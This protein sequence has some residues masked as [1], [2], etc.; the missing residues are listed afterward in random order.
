[1]NWFVSFYKSSLGKKAAMAVSGLV[2]FGFVLGHMVGNL[3]AFLG[4]EALNHYAEWLREVGEP[5]LP[6]GVFLW[7]A[8][9]VLLASVG[10]HILAAT[11]LTL[12]NWRARPESYRLRKRVQLDYASRTMRWSGV[13]VGLY[14]IY[15]LMH[16]TWGNVHRDFIP[17]DVYHN[18]VT[19]FQSPLIAG[20][21][22]LANLLL[23][24]HLYHGLWSLFQSLGW[25]HPRYNSWRRTFAVAFAVIVTAGFISV[26]LAVLAGIITIP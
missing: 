7:I 23:G 25:N 11:Q 17:G 12:Q 10:I 20:V 22:V 24:L 13:I 21:Y 4:E 16:F 19:A 15:H 9:L 6:H 5:F 2:L 14:V 8:R 3:K 26:P 18:V 1:M